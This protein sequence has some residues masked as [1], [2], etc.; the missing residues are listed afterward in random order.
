MKIKAIALLSGGLDSILAAKIVKDQGIDVFGICFK[1][2]FFNP[3]KIARL[4]AK[5][6]AIPLKVIDI[7]RAQFNIVKNP[8]YGW[9]KHINPCIDCHILM[10]KKAKD[11][12]QKE[13]FNFII[14]GEVAGQ[15]PMS[16]R[17]TILKLIEKEA[18]LEGLILRPL[19]AKL[20]EKTIPEKMGWIKRNKLF[21]ISGRSR[22]KQL[23]LAKK[24]K[25]KS[26]TTPAGGC[27]LTDP[28]FS[29][30]LKNLIKK[31]PEAKTKKEVEILKLGRHFGENNTLIIIGRNKEENSN[32]IKNILKGDIILEMR[33][34]PG[35]TCL[36]RYLPENY[37]I[38]NKIIKK[39][40]KL[41]EMYSK[42]LN[43]HTPVFYLNKI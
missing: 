24:F 32:L 7:S 42:K 20:L 10:L 30:R 2:Y 25:I 17:K 13:N 27:L 28:Q 35:P 5:E 41:I 21:S 36:I 18:G 37:N 26:Y 31:H 11:L 38:Q 15:R 14:T 4:Q 39:A 23:I 3:E 34:I 43:K 1:S 29:E 6:I 12:M 40:K 16:Q 8:K 19:S 33:D 22:K 9:G